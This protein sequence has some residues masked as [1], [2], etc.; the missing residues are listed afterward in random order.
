MQIGGTDLAF[1]GELGEGPG[2]ALDLLL[3]RLDVVQVHV[4]VAH[5]VDELACSRANR[6]RNMPVRS[7]ALKLDGQQEHATV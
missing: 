3:E 5:L 2:R 6:T 7:V 1:D 4:R